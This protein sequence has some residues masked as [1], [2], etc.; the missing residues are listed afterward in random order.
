MK[1]DKSR[2]S[3]EKAKTSAPREE[4]EEVE[5]GEEEVSGERTRTS[6]PV[7]TCKCTVYRR[8]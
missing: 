5:E 2:K 6:V 8:T 4:E 1:T 7:V 3:G